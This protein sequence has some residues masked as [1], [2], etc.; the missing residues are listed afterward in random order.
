MKVHIIGGGNLGVSVAL[1][2]ARF[3]KN[4]QITVTRRNT[5]S[6]LHLEELGITVS[7]DN[8]HNIQE[9]DIII[10]TIKPYQVDTV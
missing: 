3:S 8:K 7:K 9:A 5:S 10:L 1:G 4:N 6:I 2:L